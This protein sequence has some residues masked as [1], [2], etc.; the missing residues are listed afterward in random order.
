[1]KPSATCHDPQCNRR[2]DCL[3]YTVRDSHPELPTVQA[4]ED[5][6]G[7]VPTNEAAHIRWCT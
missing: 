7:F 3:R 4:C 1:M 6:K 5:Y 2:H